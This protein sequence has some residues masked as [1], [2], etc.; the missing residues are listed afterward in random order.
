MDLRLV[1]YDAD[2]DRLGTLPQPLSLDLGL[3]LNDLPSLTVK[4]T[5]HAA[6]GELASRA[7]H[8]GTIIA[9]EASAGGG[10]NEIAGARFIVQRYST[11]TTD[12]LRVYDLTCT[13]WVAELRY[14]IIER[15]QSGDSRNFINTNPGAI[16]ARLLNVVA[17]SGGLPHLVYNF[18]HVADSA[19]QEWGQGERLQQVEYQIGDD[20]LSVLQNLVELGIVDWTTRGDELLLY[21]PNTVL[22]N[23]W[24]GDADF[25][26]LVIGRDITEAPETATF[27]D[28]ASRIVVRG[29]DGLEVTETN[30]S[31]PTPFGH[32]TIYHSAGGVADE[33]TLR[34]I[35]QLEL[36]QRAVTKMELTRGISLAKARWLPILN[37]EPGDYI[38][39]PGAGQEMQALRVRQVTLTRDEAGMV[40][41]NVTLNDRFVE[42]ELRNALKL[43]S[44][45][46]GVSG[47]GTD[48]DPGEDRPERQVPAIVGQPLVSTE[49]Y[50]DTMGEPRGQ[51]NLS[52]SPVTEDTQGR[53]I[54]IES[55][56]LGQRHIAPH[57]LGGWHAMQHVDEPPASMSPFEID[58]VW[59]F[60]VRARSTSGVYGAWS[61]PAEITIAR[62]TEPPPQPQFREQDISSRLGTVALDI[63]GLTFQGTMMPPDTSHIAAHISLSTGFTPTP[64]T[65]YDSVPPNVAGVIV[66]PGLDYNDT[67]YVK[68][69]AVDTS[70]NWSEP[71]D[72]Q[73]ATVEPLVDE[74]LFET[75]I[76]DR[77]Q[78]AQDA[79]SD[80]NDNVI[81]GVVSGIEG[82]LEVIR[83][84]IT[85]ADGRGPTLSVNEPTV[86]DEA[87]KPEGAL[88]YRYSGGELIGMWRLGAS[89]WVALPLSRTI[90]PAV[91]IGTGTFGD[92]DGGRLK[93]NTVATRALAVGGPR[94]HVVD[95]GFA[96][97]DLR[98][99]RASVSS[100]GFFETFVQRP[101]AT[102]TYRMNNDGAND[103]ADFHLVSAPAGGWL[104]N[105]IPVDAPLRVRFGVWA[106][107][108]PGVQFRFTVRTGSGFSSATGPW[109]SPGGLEWFEDVLNI[110]SGV[111]EMDASLQV[112]FAG[113]DTGSLIRF[114]L[115]TWEAMTPGVLIE[116]G[117]IVA[118]HITSNSIDTRHLRALSVETGHLKANAIT[119]DKADI[120]DLRGEIISGRVIRGEHLQIGTIGPRDLSGVGVNHVTDP[121]FEDSAYW[122]GINGALI[123]FGNSGGDWSSATA[124]SDSGTRSLRCQF[125]GG[126]AAWQYITPEISAPESNRVYVAITGRR[127]GGASAPASDVQFTLSVRCIRNNG[128]VEYQ[129]SSWRNFPDGTAWS[130][131]EEVVGLPGYTAAYQVRVFVRRAGGGSLANSQVFFDSAMVQDATMSKGRSE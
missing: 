71:S 60:R 64:A 91:D 70:G 31:A 99:H 24:D 23:R 3:P 113:T 106:R 35:G 90:L 16:M 1:A 130:A 83:N 39:A 29:K 85:L 109:R 94:N 37:Y 67:I 57:N 26:D 43:A 34:K 116:D 84:N 5:E 124:T 40:S 120:G 81:P 74:D 13:S 75:T 10:W 27:E 59:Q 97:P 33:G 62:D 127:G 17:D 102:Y 42:K 51:V 61:V 77:F 78:S 112:D 125:S 98:A 68:L 55:Y 49:T 4:Y 66:I 32:R 101:G 79:I 14:G 122:N 12:E 48:S 117:A 54:E 88:W 46:R 41:G 25:R 45:L 7:L 95:P 105:L 11:D 56:Q 80:I 107:A 47:S 73:S 69:V 96:D 82:D 93:A 36:A 22:A 108:N 87:G 110:P 129:T 86:A 126:T 18:G 115:P 114:E 121:S 131:L 15:N 92:L 50:L 38:V 100:T 119:A 19:G 72:E 9:V 128:Q 53:T 65:E 76:D 20:L 63:T 52:W 123:Q 118:D 30:P 44:I 2:G 28:V 89:G 8:A 104:D 21:R 111:T 58:S 6:R 103:R